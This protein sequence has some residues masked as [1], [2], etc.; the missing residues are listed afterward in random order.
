[1]GN[2][3]EWSELPDELLMLAMLYLDIHYDWMRYVDELALCD[4]CWYHD[5]SSNVACFCDACINICWFGSFP[6]CGSEFA[7]PIDLPGGR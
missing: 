6:L 3:Y 4:I 1:M 5:L 2:Y 7:E